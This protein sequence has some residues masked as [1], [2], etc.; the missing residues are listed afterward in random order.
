MNRS[1]AE[2]LDPQQRLLLEVVWECMENAGQT[3]WHGSNTSCYV[4]VFGEDWLD[5][6]TKDPQVLRPLHIT[7]ASDFSL[8]SN[9]VRVQSAGP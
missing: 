8:K 4:G 5:L 7:G 3:A 6:T 9:F 1:E 2:I